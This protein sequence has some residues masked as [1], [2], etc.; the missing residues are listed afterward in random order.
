MVIRYSRAFVN[1]VRHGLRGEEIAFLTEE[2]YA[3]HEHFRA[4]RDK[5]FAHSV[6][7]FEDTRI[8][9]RYCLERVDEEGITGIGAA[10]YRVLGLSGDDLTTI[11]DLCEC[12]LERISEMENEE[13]RRLL[14]FIRHLP[15]ADVLS[16]KSSPLLIPSAVS[17]E[18]RRKRP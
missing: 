1:G 3:A 18:K 7:A 5:H 11:V 8:Q 2:Q 17:S 6:N 4:L 14:L 12:I 13:K 9:A 15:L 16:A 10:H